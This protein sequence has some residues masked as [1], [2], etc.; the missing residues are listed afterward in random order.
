M[1]LLAETYL[2]AGRVEEAYG[3]LRQAMAWAAD[4]GERFYEAELHRLESRVLLSRGATGEAEASL[5]R[6]LVVA[7][8]QQTQLFHLKAARDLARLW[9]ERGERRR[10]HDLLAPIY[11]WFSEGFDTPDVREAKALLDALN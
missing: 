7:R 4:Q 3:A 9:G 10:A 5:K 2:A 6:A 8:A 11:D 1:A